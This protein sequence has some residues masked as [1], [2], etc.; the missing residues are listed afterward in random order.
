M[1]ALKFAAWTILWIPNIKKKI[2]EMLKSGWDML[3][4]QTCDILPHVTTKYLIERSGF[5]GVVVDI[6]R[7]FPRNQ[8]GSLQGLDQVPKWWIINRNLRKVVSKTL[9]IHVHLLVDHVQGVCKW[10]SI[11][12]KFLWV[13]SETGCW[14]LR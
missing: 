10:A 9:K 2:H 4:P 5:L 1:V 7:N 14:Y 6:L 3:A 11:F 8:V 13:S 12:R